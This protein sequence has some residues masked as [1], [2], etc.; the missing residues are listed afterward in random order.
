MKKFLLACAILFAAFTAHAEVKVGAPAPEFL[1]TD[2]E[3]NTVQLSK[4]KGKIVVLE[5]YNKDCP[6]VRKH[7]DTGNMQSLQT[8]AKESGA[9]WLNINSSAKDKQ[10]YLTA[11]EA[12]ANTASE[13]SAANHVLLDPTGSIGKLYGA[14]TTPHLFVI[15]KAGAV[16][17]M[18][19]IDDKSS[20]DKEDVPTARNY[21]KDAI[22]ALNN[23]TV[24][25]V[26]AT[27]SYGCSVKY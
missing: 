23:G 15:D 2:I 25:E 11:E 16:A 24:P 22:T 7:Y 5:W 6:F 20:A 13:K 19:A 26:Q 12:I 4:L 27:S 18:G 21:V 8:W 14:K 3:G 17:Y 1:A 10:G 9:V